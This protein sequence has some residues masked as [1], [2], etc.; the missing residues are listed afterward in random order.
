MNSSQ[1]LF[2]ASSLLLLASGCIDLPDIDPG[3][4]EKLDSGSPPTD[5]GGPTPDSGTPDAGQTDG[6]TSFC[7]DGTI[8]RDEGELCD[9][10]NAQS[11]DGC[12]ADC[13][14]DETCGN[15]IK[16]T[17]RNEVCDDGNTV[18]ETECPYGMMSCIRCN[19]SCSHEMVLSGPYCGDNTLS[20][21]EACDDGNT[22]TETQCPYGTSLCTRCDAICSESLNLM[23]P[24]CGDGTQD[25]EEACDDGNTITETE[26][27]YSTPSCTRCDA[28]CSA[29]LSLNGPYC[30]DGIANGA[31]VCD[32]GN[33]VTETQCSYGTATCSACSAA[34][35][36]ALSLTGPYCGDGVQNGSEVCDDG[37]VSACGTCSATCTQVQ[38]SKATGS[39]IV[40]D[41]SRIVDSD[42]LMIDDGINGNVTFEFDADGEVAPDNIRVILSGSNSTLAGRV[43]SAIN[44]SLLMITANTSGNAVTLVHDQ[45][46]VLGNR[47]ILSG[48]SSTFLAISGMSGGAGGDCGG[49]VGCTRNEDCAI[50]LVC[51][52]NHTCGP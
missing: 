29:M 40:L 21:S 7:G 8:D 26:C 18:T 41:A 10:G 38:S 33:T 35:D 1:A 44:G 14:S 36:T 39:I 50:G 32:D 17:A 13:R 45:S 31:E 46:T 28:T 43:A 19:A 47:A 34:C 25:S 11:G 30:G 51:R 9:D 22:V 4:V 23:G 52:P 5:E 2:L 20:D 3:E 48:A 12:S 49:G 24:Y 15:G 37:N 42:P 6:G 16:D 27:P